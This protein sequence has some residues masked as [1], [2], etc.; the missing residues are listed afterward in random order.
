MKL[1]VNQVTEK[2]KTEMTEILDEFGSVFEAIGKIRDNKND[3]ELYV[4]VNMKP[5]I[6]PVAQKPRQV[7]TKLGYIQRKHNDREITEEKEINERDKCYKEKIKHKAEN[8]N[9]RKH[10]FKI[11]DYVLL[12]QNKRDKWST[13]CEPAF[14][15]IFVING[16]TVGARRVSDGREIHRDASKYKLANALIQEDEDYGPPQDRRGRGRTGER[17]C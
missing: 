8:R 14:Y 11:E 16:S 10:D 13:A 3:S 15:N 1:D 7:R 17:I 5:G 9:T 12:E 4:K 6:A 2:R